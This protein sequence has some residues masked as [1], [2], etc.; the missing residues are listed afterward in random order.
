MIDWG[1]PKID[2]FEKCNVLLEI[3][4]RFLK[5]KIGQK[6]QSDEISLIEVIGY[7]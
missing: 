4:V 6:I 2:R 5:M 3:L 7:S 1:G